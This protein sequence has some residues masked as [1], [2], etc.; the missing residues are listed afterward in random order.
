MDS[1]TRALPGLLSPHD[2]RPQMVRL[3]QD[4]DAE[5]EKLMAALKQSLDAA[6]KAE[7]K[8]SS[9]LGD[10][11]RALKRAEE[12]L[13]GVNPSLGGG[14]AGGA[15]VSPG[16]EKSQVAWGRA[17]LGRR[18]QGRTGLGRPESGSIG[19][20]RTVVRAVDMAEGNDLMCQYRLVLCTV[21]TTPRGTR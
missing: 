21:S 4:E 17:G 2:A 20:G 18:G 1:C 12:K 15:I 10:A 11:K 19:P 5:T 3:A 14:A 9:E 13:K 16:N 7:A 6:Q 8:R